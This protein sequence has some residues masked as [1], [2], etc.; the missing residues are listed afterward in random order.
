MSFTTTISAD[1]QALV[2]EFHAAHTGL[3]AVT[4]EEA[5]L[6]DAVHAYLGLGVT[7]EEEEV[8]LNC[9]NLLAGLGC[10]AHLQARCEFLI[11]LLTTD[12]L[13]ELSVV[14]SQYYC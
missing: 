1:T 3:D 7:L 10:S 11:S 4:T 9:V 12:V 13:V 14:A 8:V 2:A 6:H 5:L